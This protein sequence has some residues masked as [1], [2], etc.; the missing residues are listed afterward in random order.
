M[1]LAGFVDSLLE[2]PIAPSFTKVG[3][4][5]RSRLEHWTNLATYDLSGRTI[6]VTGATSGIGRQAAEEFAR[7]GAHVVISGRDPAKA[8]RVLNEIAVRTGSSALT[9][10]CADMSELDQVQEMAEQL[11]AAHPRIDALV[12]NAGAL[13]S[14]RA[15]NSAGIESTVASQVLGP[16]LLTSR[17]LPVLSEGGPGRV[18]TMSSGGMYAAGLT[19][20]NLQMTEADYRGSEQ[21]AR[22]KR[23]QV[24]L[25]EMWAKRV[26]IAEVVFHAL[27]PG[28]ADTPGVEASLPQ[29]RRLM[30]PLLRTPSEG[31]DTLVWLAAD[32]GEPLRTSGDFWLDRKR[33]QIHRLPS[34]R[35]SDTPQRRQE[36]WDWC[37]AQTR[38]ILSP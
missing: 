15:V 24:T 11:V 29:F 34:T 1:K 9:M 16:F 13:T 18:I 30:K 10:A 7:L 4:Q 8:R 28:W 17:L 5:L 2:V 33:R 32:G 3:Y 38:V 20:D 12:H 19:V 23:A 36:L 27:H 31:A 22:A 25:N 6:V 26:E 14:H 21:Y 37:V 35:R